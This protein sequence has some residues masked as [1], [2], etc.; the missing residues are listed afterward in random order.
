MLR[1]MTNEK[2]VCFVRRIKFNVL[3]KLLPRDA[4]SAERGIATL[5]Y[6]IY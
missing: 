5:M 1:P 3:C 2:S 4:L 6:V